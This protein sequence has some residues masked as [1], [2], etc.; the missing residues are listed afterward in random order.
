MLIHFNDYIGEKQT[1]ALN[2]K[3]IQEY[4]L[5]YRYTI[6]DDDT[7]GNKDQSFQIY[8]SFSGTMSYD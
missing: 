8:D 1:P 2:F 5:H 3:T 6:I 7:K 4:N